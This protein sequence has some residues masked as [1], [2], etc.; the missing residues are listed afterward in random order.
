MGITDVDVKIEAMKRK[1]EKKLKGVAI[2]LW[3]I[4]ITII[5]QATLLLFILANSVSMNDVTTAIEDYFEST[6]ELAQVQ[7]FELYED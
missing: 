5:C 4:I 2:L 1:I 7:N 3:L 6:T